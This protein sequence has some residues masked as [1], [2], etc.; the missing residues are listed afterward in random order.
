MRLKK[1]EGEKWFSI[2]D[3]SNRKTKT[4]NGKGKLFT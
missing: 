2:F 4:K 3:N 1:K